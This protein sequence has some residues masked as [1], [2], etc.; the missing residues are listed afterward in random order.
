MEVHDLVP[1]HDVQGYGKNLVSNEE[2]DDAVLISQVFG[3]GLA[4]ANE[5]RIGEG[6]NG[7]LTAGSPED[8]RPGD[9]ARTLIR[10]GVRREPAIRPGFRACPCDQGKYPRDHSGKAGAPRWLLSLPCHVPPPLKSW[11]PEA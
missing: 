11:L 6:G 2:A 4:G 3:S 1:P 7:V 9:D 5:D 8:L 10:G